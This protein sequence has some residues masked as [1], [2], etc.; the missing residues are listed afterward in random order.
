L[1]DLSHNEACSGS[2][3]IESYD[4]RGDRSEETQKENDA[5]GGFDPVQYRVGS[6]HAERVPGGTKVTE[7]T[8]L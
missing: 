2:R 6:F 1:V 4:Q 7:R 5:A 3:T 8:G